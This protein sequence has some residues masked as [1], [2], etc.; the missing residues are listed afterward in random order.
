MSDSEPRPTSSQSVRAPRW[1]GTKTRACRLKFRLEV[2]MV[3]RVSGSRRLWIS[4][5][6]T[7]SLASGST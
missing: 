3:K 7:F 6:E 4:T 2:A 5:R 1:A